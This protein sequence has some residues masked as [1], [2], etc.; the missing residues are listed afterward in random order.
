MLALRCRPVQ[1]TRL[2]VTVHIALRAPRPQV[3]TEVSKIAPARPLAEL[4]QPL[5]DRV[6]KAIDKAPF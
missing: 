6:E 2:T 1:E 3:A 5:L 4:K